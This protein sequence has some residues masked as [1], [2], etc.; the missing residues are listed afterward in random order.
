MNDLKLGVIGLS[1]GN[2]HPYSWSAI[3]NG[4]DPVAMEDCGFP[5]IARYLK[6]QSWPEA[7]LGGAD[8]THVWTQSAE[9]SRSIAEATFI[10]EI[11]ESLEDLVGTVD[12]VL[13]A[14]DDHEHH[15]EHA[16]PFLDAGIPIYIDKPIAT[17]RAR[18]NELRRRERF[19]GHIFTCSALRYA[20]EM[21]LSERQW[22]QIG[23]VARVHAT[24]PKDWDRY[25]VHIIEPITVM[26]G[27]S[28][29]IETVAVDTNT[30]GG[31][32]VQII[33]DG[34]IEVRFTATG[35]PSGP[36]VIEV[37]GTGGSVAL[38]EPDTFNAFKAALHDFANGVRAGEERTNWAHVDR[39]VEILEIGVR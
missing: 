24:T 16:G 11:A 29:P 39:T 22:E 33:W 6:Q 9:L 26:L 18:L 31:T 21:Q 20:P 19:P 23:K 32:T 37:I 4:Y 35:E 38:S 1:H 8:V 5:V 12:A 15:L 28:R 2:G 27:S 10:P 36:M 3:V 14:R 25:A 34:S 17:S 13:L 7:R 30:D